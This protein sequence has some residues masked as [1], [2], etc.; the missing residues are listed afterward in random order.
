MTL[1]LLLVFWG[2][3]V[4][5]PQGKSCSGSSKSPA[6][7]GHD[8]YHQ[9]FNDSTSIHLRLHHVHGPDCFHLAPPLRLS[10]ILEKDEARVGA[11]NSRIS[12]SNSNS[13]SSSS[14]SS[15]SEVSVPL[16]PG[17]SIGTGNYYVTIG[18]GTPPQFFPVVVDTGSSFNWVQ[19]QPCIVYCHPQQGAV[20]N[21]LASKSYMRVPC[22]APECSALK[23]ATLNAPTCSKAKACVYDASYGD[24]SF[25]LGYLSRDALTLGA[26]APLL[27]SFVY[28]C[29]QNNQ[30]LFGKSAGII[31]L[32]R[33]RLS[34]LAQLSSKVGY[35][36]SYCLPSSSGGGSGSLS[37]GTS[38]FNP[39]LFRFTPMLTAPLDATLYFLRLAAITVAGKPLN[40]VTPMQYG[41]PTIIDSGTVVT[42][43]AAPVYAALRDAFVKAMGP[44]FQRLPPISILDTCFR[45]GVAMAAVPEVRLVFQGGAELKLG[46]PNLLLEAKNGVACLA[47]AATSGVSIIGNIQQQTYTVAYDIANSRIGFA[48]AGCR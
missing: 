27:P 42:R 5:T 34:M 24:G 7:E 35:A 13:S 12:R 1:L 37:I 31:G 25:S 18:L 3:L 11:L 26:G 21:N 15:S 17:M 44:R 6:D 33:N 45:G 36:F 9:A 43:L 10:D 47:F 14:S 38:S 39:S 28:G 40:A 46:P 19:C 22:A 16:K 30:G 23:E 4:A 2:F 29:G 48:A 41:G 20:F 8:E 32:A